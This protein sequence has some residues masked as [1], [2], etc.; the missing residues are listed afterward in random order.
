MRFKKCA[1]CDYE[2]ETRDDLIYDEDI[3][4]VGYQAHFGNLDLG[5][6]LFNHVASNCGTTLSIKVE[7]FLELYHVCVYGEDMSSSDA[8]N[9]YCQK[10]NTTEECE[11]DCECNFVRQIMGCLNDIDADKE[12]YKF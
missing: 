8:C 12:A 3:R 11:N 7:S 6:L 9:G 5:Y 4:F 2:W 10:G 1:N